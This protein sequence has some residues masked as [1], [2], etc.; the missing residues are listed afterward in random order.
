MIASFSFLFIFGTIM[1][2]SFAVT[3]LIIV[4]KLL[5]CIFGLQPR[6]FALTFEMYKIQG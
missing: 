2:V 3:Y 5:F 6:I 4:K 1:L